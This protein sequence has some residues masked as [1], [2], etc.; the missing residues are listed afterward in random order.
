[1]TYFG[2]EKFALIAAIF[3]LGGLVIR[4]RQWPI[5]HWLALGSLIIYAGVFGAFRFR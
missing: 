1:M 5:K 4:W 3:C 2:D